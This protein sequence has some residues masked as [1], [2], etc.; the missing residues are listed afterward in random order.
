M[1]NRLALIPALAVLLLAG[2]SAGEA[3]APTVDTA[4]PAAV[5]AAPS[6][7]PSTAPSVAASPSVRTIAITV[8]GGKV[9][10]T[11]GREQVALGESVVIRVTSDIAEEVHV[12][13]YD[14]MADV[15]A[16]GT[17]DIP[18]TASIPGGFEVELE[19][20]GKTL[21]QLRVA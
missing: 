11:S 4:T 21:F 16:G 15:P 5:S 20:S 8:A 9:T 10:G 13:G 19:G 7:A 18:L 3:D 12:H 17:V 14:L 1:R 6:N 2:C